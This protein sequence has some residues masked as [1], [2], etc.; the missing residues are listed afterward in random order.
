[1][2]HLFK[3]P[4]LV[5]SG[6]L[7]LITSSAAAQS[8]AWLIFPD[9]PTLPALDC[10]T[11]NAGVEDLLVIDDTRDLET[12]DGFLVPGSFVDVLGSVAT[13]TIDEEGTEAWVV[14]DVFIDNAPFGFLAFTDDGDDLRTRAFSRL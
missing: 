14:A 3:N 2:F 4:A 6:V 8:G 1:M 13:F 10:D 5:V 9:D 7:M 11:V 12:I